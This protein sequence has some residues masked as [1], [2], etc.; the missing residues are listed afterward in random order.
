[1][2]HQIVRRFDS[3]G[4]IFFEVSPVNWE[5]RLVGDN[6]TNPIPSFVGKFINKMVLFRNRLGFMSDEN[7]ILSRPG[8]YFNFWT[9]TAQ[10]VSPI[11]PIDISVSSSTPATLF[12]AVEVN[13]GLLMFSRDH[14]FLLTTD[15]DALTPETAKVNNLSTY[16]FN[17]KTSPF[18]MGTTVGFLNNA[19][20]NTRLF[21]ITNIRREGEA[22]VLDQSK[23][24]DNL[25]PPNVDAVTH[26]RTNN[27]VLLGKKGTN[28]IHG[29]QYF[30]TGEKRAQSAWFKWELR[31]NLVSHFIV[32]DVYYVVIDN[33]GNI[34]LQTIEL[35]HSDNSAIQ[36]I[37]SEIPITIHMDNWKSILTSEIT[38]DAATKTSTFELPD[39]SITPVTDYECGR[40]LVMVIKVK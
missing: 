5:R 16:A 30:N 3:S 20:R 9:K 6:L 19:G 22:E 14:Q 4:N 29:Y 7:I 40:F 17:V 37:N 21:E 33:D 35:R 36:Q 8:D 11:D 10:V 38:Y 23:V 27:L 18:S 32:D 1:M 2:S 25:L 28:L 31:G 15:N 26:S 34:S 39:G 12:D 24:I 13:A